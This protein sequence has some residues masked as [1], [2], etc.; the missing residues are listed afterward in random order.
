MERNIK[1]F[2]I[3]ECTSEECCKDCKDKTAWCFQLCKR[4]IPDN[5]FATIKINEYGDKR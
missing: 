2:I 1:K 4:Y 3:E 5:N